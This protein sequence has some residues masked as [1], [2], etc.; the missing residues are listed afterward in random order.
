L[1]FITVGPG[2]P[3]IAAECRWKARGATGFQRSSRRDSAG[4]FSFEESLAQHAA[5][6]RFQAKWRP[7]R[8]KKTRQVKKLEPRFDSIETEKA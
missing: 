1:R 5:P 2:Q 7:V 6:K 4:A 3:S 8:V